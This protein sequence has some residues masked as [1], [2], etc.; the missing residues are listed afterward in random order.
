MIQCGEQHNLAEG[1]TS[2]VY[3]AAL[4]SSKYAS[5][6]WAKVFFAVA[7]GVPYRLLVT[8]CVTTTK[9]ILLHAATVAYNMLIHIQPTPCVSSLHP[10]T[11]R[12]CLLMFAN[13]VRPL[14]NYLPCTSQVFI[15]LYIEYSHFG[16]MYES[17]LQIAVSC[18]TFKFVHRR[19]HSLR[20]I[21]PE[22]YSSAGT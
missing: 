19:P 14:Q 13:S 11:T 18:T 6:S 9:Y 17:H 5:F 21:C 4:C 8:G 10:S 16:L 12:K 22:G 1:T 2:A 3:A 7:P 15:I 20:I